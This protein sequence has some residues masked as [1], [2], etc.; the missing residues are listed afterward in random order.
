MYQ[1]NGIQGKTRL[2]SYMDDLLVQISAVWWIFIKQRIKTN[3]NTI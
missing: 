2:T 3:E 1:R